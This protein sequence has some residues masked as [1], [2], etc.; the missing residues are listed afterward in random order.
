MAG[1]GRIAAAA[2]LAAGVALAAGPKQAGGGSERNAAKTGVAPVGAGCFWCVEA[3][4]RELDGVL[5]VESGYSGGTMERSTYEEV[6][7]GDTGHAEAVQIR[8]NPARVRY[9]DLLEVFFKTHDPTTL[10]RQGAD[11]GTQYRSVI[12]WHDAAQKAAA[13]K[14]KKA[15]DAAH[16]WPDPIVTAIVPFKAF[17]KAEDHHQDYYARNRAAP[18]C[19]FVI[20]PKLDKF[21]KVF[22]D[23][24]KPAAVR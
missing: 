3:F 17:F 24:L 23:K 1:A 15:L 4:F 22:K 13:E 7:S 21:R 12:F 19:L 8:W 16:A 20:R 11:A 10:N 18:Y 5:S 14:A 2:C 6:C 9:E